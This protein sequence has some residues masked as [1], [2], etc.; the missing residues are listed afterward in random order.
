M[1]QQTSGDHKAEFGSVRL[2]ASR[3]SK[4]AP[5]VLFEH[6]KEKEPWLIHMAVSSENCPLLYWQCK[7]MN[8]H[9]Y[10]RVNSEPCSK[11]NCSRK[12]V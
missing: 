10:C 1:L 4:V 7:G 3:S 2:G 11:E 6:Q 5:S 12:M 8:S 9:W